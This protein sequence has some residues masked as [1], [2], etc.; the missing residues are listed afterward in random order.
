MDGI[1]HRRVV[2]AVVERPE[3]GRAD[4]VGK[5][6]IFYR[7]SLEQL[8]I[9]EQYPEPRRAPAHRAELYLMAF[10]RDN[11]VVIEPLVHA[12]D[13]EFHIFLLCKFSIIY[14]EIN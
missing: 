5:R 6:F 9:L 14:C 2:V 4:T 8:M 7:E 12:F 3:N 1:E 13:C 10:I 11:A